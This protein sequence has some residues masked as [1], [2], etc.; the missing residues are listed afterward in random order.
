MEISLLSYIHPCIGELFD[1]DEPE[2]LT[3][4]VVT[5]ESGRS[6]WGIV[7][8]WQVLVKAS[9]MW[10]PL[11]SLVWSAHQG[12]HDGN[13]KQGTLGNAKLSE[14]STLPYALV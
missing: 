4:W 5:E 13:R 12:L 2:P 14:G 3:P 10:Y 6:L 9:C 11:G 8:A 7:T 1:E